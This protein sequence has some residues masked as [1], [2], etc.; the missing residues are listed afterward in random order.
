MRIRQAFIGA[1]S[2]AALGAAT[3][4]YSD[5]AKT[6]KSETEAAEAKAKSEAAAPAAHIGKP[7]TAKWSATTYEAAATEANKKVLNSGKVKTVTGEVVDVSCYMQL[8]KRGEA[9]VACGTKCITNGQPIG[10]VDKEGDLYILFAE[11]H[12]PRRD[13]QVD[14][15]KIFLP[16]L[17]KNV[18]VTGIMTEMKGYRALFVQAAETADSLKI[19]EVEKK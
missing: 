6:A 8:G 15:K 5:A 11:E 19:E 13:G 17:A 4:V 10:L 14:L 9:H 2:L 1:L 18:A 7:E 3:L 12:H 16:L